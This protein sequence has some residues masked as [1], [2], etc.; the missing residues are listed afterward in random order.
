MLK[1]CSLSIILG[2]LLLAACTPAATPTPVATQVPVTS[3]PTI[4]P[5]TATPVPRALNICLGQEPSSLYLYA[6]NRSQAMWS[7]LEAIYDG[8]IDYVNFAYQPVILE[9]VPSLADGD[10]KLEPVTVKSGMDMVDV[11]GNLR[12]LQKDVSYFPTGCSSADCIK[13]Y[14]GK[15]EIQMDQLTVQ[16]KLKSGLTWSD[17]TPMTAADSVY[18]FSLAGNQAAGGNK[19]LI[20]KTTSFTAVDEL[21]AEWK[22]VPGFL[23]QQYMTRFWIPQPEHVYSGKDPAALGE[24]PLA[25]EKPIG[26]GP[27]MISEWVA[28]DHIKLVKNPSYFRASE[29]LPRL[30]VINYRFL[31]G[32]SQQSME[33]LLSGECDVIDESTLLDD[34]LKSIKDLQAAGKLQSAIS[35][36][37]VWEGLYFGVKPALYDTNQSIYNNARPDYFSDVRTRQAISMCINKEKI[38]EE[39]WAGYSNIPASYLS[40]ENPVVLQNAPGYSYDPDKANALLDQ[41]GWKDYDNNPA[42]PR[43]A[44]NMSNVYLGAPLV[45]NYYT[46]N[47]EARKKAASLIAAD[48]AQCEIQVNIQN[49]P[50]EELFISGPDGVLFGRKFDLAEFS[51]S[52]SSMAPC[53]FY[54]TGQINTAANSWVGVNVSGYSAAEFDTACQSA[55]ASL[56]GQTDYIEKQQAAQ[57]IFSTDLPVIPLYQMLRIGLARTD[58]CGYQMDST[59]RSGLWNIEKLDYGTTCQ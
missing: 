52:P 16:F 37:M 28:G 32:T 33:A 54:S 5:P 21:T 49:L 24:D 55:A 50:P 14:D 34:Q 13:Q 8:P 26:W 4:P 53:R 58:L 9:K 17:G 47:A 3:A 48:L 31:N 45:L 7:V 36:S 10:A 41:I 20:K 25:K 35:G 15:A 44:V 56:P 38:L 27:F 46:T 39:V 43:V 30:D 1:K 19:E 22:G 11:D 2:T 6:A 12:T 40:P 29:G 51:W 42:T 18:S 23:D 59:S 57:T